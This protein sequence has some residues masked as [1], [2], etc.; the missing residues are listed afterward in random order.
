M[1]AVPITNTLFPPPPGYYKAFTPEALARLAELRSEG[2]SA[3]PLAPGELDELAVALDPPR[4]DW[5]LEEGQWMLFGQKYTAEPHIPTARDIGLPA[6]VSDPVS[7]GGDSERAALPLLLH[8]FLHTL[9]AFVDVLTGTARVPDE[10]EAYGRQSQGD[11]YIQ[12]MSNLAATMMVSAN[13][14]RGVQAEATL[15]M[16][17]EKQLE[18]RRAQ[19]ERLRTKSREIAAMVRRLKENA[20][21]EAGESRNPSRSRTNS[22]TL[23]ESQA[24]SLKLSPAANG[25][26]ESDGDVLMSEV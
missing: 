19:T 3:E 2:D 16:L 13:Q 4:A 12:H 18:E 17:M 5:V 10:L 26:G 7:A 14:L 8:S 1:A 11:Q 15:V 9:L 23:G 22:H 20:T 21:A 25:H 24:V 6:L